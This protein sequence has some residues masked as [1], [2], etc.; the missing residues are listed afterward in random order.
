MNF[1]K[2]PCHLKKKTADVKYNLNLNFTRFFLGLLV[3]G[4]RFVDLCNLYI[5]HFACV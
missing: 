4:G 5:H 2:G 3:G 1:E